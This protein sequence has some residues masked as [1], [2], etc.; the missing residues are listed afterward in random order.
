MENNSIASYYEGEY[1]INPANGQAVIRANYNSTFGT[2]NPPYPRLYAG[3]DRKENAY[4]ANLVN[5]SPAAQG[6]IIFG[7]VISGI[8]GFFTTATFSTDTTTDPG[9]EKQLFSVATDFFS[10]NGY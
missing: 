2:V 6:E 10:N 7:N 4:V 9:G 5:N 3:F 8:K 1:I